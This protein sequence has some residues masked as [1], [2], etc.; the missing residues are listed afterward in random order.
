[1][2]MP[3][4][5]MTEDRAGKPAPQ[6]LRDQGNPTITVIQLAHHAPN[7]RESGISMITDVLP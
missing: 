2:I 7:Y 3:R 5:D 4:T 6:F 1:V